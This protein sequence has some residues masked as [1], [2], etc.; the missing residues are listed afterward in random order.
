M[1]KLTET[2]IDIA[3]CHTT[4][5]YL[6]MKLPQVAPLPLGTAQDYQGLYEK[7]AAPNRVTYNDVSG[8]P[9][10]MLV[11]LSPCYRKN[12]YWSWYLGSRQ[13]DLYHE[14]AWNNIIPVEVSL[15]TR[16]EFITD[17][18]FNFKVSPVPRVLLYPFGW[19]AW[20][21]LRLTD[22]HTVEELSLFL[23]H[24]F[25]AKAFRIATNSA[26][27]NQPPP[28]YSLLDLFDLIAQGVRSDSFGGNKTKDFDSQEMIAVTTV[29]AKHGGSL[30][31]GALSDAM[32]QQILRIV[33]P[34][35]PV[36]KGK[37]L[38]HVFRRSDDELDE[39][40][41]MDSYKRFIWLEHLLVSQNRNYEHLRCYHN[42]TFHSLVQARQLLELLVMAGKQSS[43]SDPLRELVE[44]AASNLDISGGN[45]PTNYRNAS[46]KQLLQDP[47]IN[48]AIKKLQKF[49]KSKKDDAIT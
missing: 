39:Y 9:G 8:T 42:N 34:D 13:H 23:Q 30:S 18:R 43:L 35:G 2:I 31:L 27:S 16:I 14:I 15:A 49:N 5:Y 32:Q 29:L 17:A 38:D 48:N 11:K 41:V 46:L 36:P 33:K 24:V 22:A 21:S 10:S 40:V 25:T 45:W 20:L 7:V 28:A 37:F 12:H 1:I 26:P 4:L 44:V 47:A 19:S 3:D 6:G